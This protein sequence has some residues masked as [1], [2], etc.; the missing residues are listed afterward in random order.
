MSRWLTVRDRLRR[1]VERFRR[2][3]LD[4]LAWT[5]RLTTGA[6][7]SFVVAQLLL[8]NQRPMLAPL[9]ALLVI[10]ATPVSLLTTGLDRVASVVIGV[11]LAVGVSV[12]LPLTWWSLTG[13][14][15]VSLL[16]GQ[17]M[18]L[19][20]NLLEVPISAMLVLGVG[21]ASTDTAASARV[22]ETLV[23]AGVGVLANLLLP[24]KVPFASAAEAVD[25]LASKLS[26]LLRRAADEVAQ[27][28]GD[29]QGIAGAADRW[30][31][32]ARSVSSDIP[33]I[34]ATLEQAEESRRFNVRMV[35][36]ADAAPGIRQA[37]E[38]LEHSLVALRS[39]FRGV[40]DAI[41]DE[42]WPGDDEGRHASVDLVEV[43]QVLA[44][45][46]ATFGR[47]V[48]AEA[49]SS[50]LSAP[51]LVSSVEEALDAVHAVQ[52]MLFERAADQNPA[53]AE[54]YV[55]LGSTVK[56]LRSELDLEDRA[57][58]Q[59]VLRPVRRSV[60]DVVTP[61]ARRRRPSS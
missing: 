4:A 42:S 49:R 11:L 30:L 37:L 38:A 25:E 3:G 43:L 41:H 55:S 39:M 15:L 33:H 50:D 19:R 17:V 7:A 59:D 46:V 24:P 60:R 35:G 32:E 44:S 12:L 6:V 34:S 5:L 47:L 26:T 53:L 28:E 57:R 31:R 16:I 2:G 10:Q 48:R 27:A 54:L 58:R 56:R 18:R 1:P 13:V 8:D 40:R 52:A 45:G 23:G 36:S 14:I 29:S 20:A 61:R 9:T 21:A 22:A 51:D